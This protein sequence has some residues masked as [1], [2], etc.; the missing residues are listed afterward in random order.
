MAEALAP[1]AVPPLTPAGQQPQ[2]DRGLLPRSR[3]RDRDAVAGVMRVRRQAGQGRPGDGVLPMLVDEIGLGRRRRPRRVSR[4]PRSRPRTTSFVEQVRGLGV[5]HPLLDEGLDELLRCSRGL[6]RSGRDRILGGGRSAGRARPRLLHRHGVREPHGGL[7]APRLDLRGRSLRRAGHRRPDDLP[8]VGISF[9]VTRTLAPLLARGLLDAVAQHAACGARRAAGEDDR[10]PRRRSPPRCARVAS[11]TEVAPT[12]AEVRQADPVRRAPRASRTSGSRGPTATPTRCATSAPESRRRCRRCHRGRP[13]RSDRTCRPAADHAAP[14]RRTEEQP[15]IRTHEAGSAARRARRPDRHPRRL[16]RP[17]PRPRWRRVH[18]PARRVSG[19]VQV[20]I[21]DEDVAHRPAQRVLPARSP[22]RSA[23]VPTGNANPNL[24]TGEIEVVVTEV[25]V[26]NEAGAAAVPD[27]GATTRSARRC[28]CKYRY[29]DLRRPAPAPRSGCAARSA[30]SPARCWHEHG[31]VEIE[32]PT[33]T[34]STPEGARDFLVP[35]RLQPGTWYALPQSPQLFKQLL[36]VAGMERYFQIA[37][38]YRDEDFR[39][40]RQPEF[41]QLDIE[42]SFVDQEDVIE[43]GEAVLVALWKLIGHDD[44]AADPA[45]D[46]RRGD[47]PVR[48]RQ[49]GP[50]LRPG[51][52]R[53]HRRTSRRRRS[54]SSRRRTSAP[55]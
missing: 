22:A 26:L 39:A 48:H 25:E 3:G 53:L 47:A 38:C 16:G 21:R 18:R 51:A 31:F 13:R 41:T 27:R 37:R 1:A 10:A 12:R 40:D 49:A 54:G 7:R 44:R 24:P 9:G 30:A 6:R 23:P 43:L 46:V 4:W 34:R 55:S 2:A 29:L 35:A 8:G 28:G 11:P 42:M 33:L 14:A 32:T 45:D 5:S 36:M 17:P 52:G 20:V 15:V 19:V 50:A